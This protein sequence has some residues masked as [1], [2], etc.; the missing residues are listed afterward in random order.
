M[1]RL[2]VGTAVDAMPGSQRSRRSSREYAWEPF[3]S[4]PAG[5]FLRALGWQLLRSLPRSGIC[6]ASRNH[7]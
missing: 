3:F 5:R 6:N 2:K 7:L 4:Y 1:S